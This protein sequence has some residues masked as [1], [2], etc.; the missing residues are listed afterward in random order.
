M[1]PTYKCAEGV[2]SAGTCQVSQSGTDFLVTPCS[3]LTE[4][5]VGFISSTPVTMPANL[6]LTTGKCT[7]QQTATPNQEPIIVYAGDKCDNNTYQCYSSLWCVPN[8]LFC[9]PKPNT[10]GVCTDDR[11]CDKGQYCNTGKCVSVI[12][13]AN[14][15]PC[16]PNPGPFSNDCGFGMMCVDFA[17][18]P[19]C[20]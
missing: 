3:N 12:G 15:S 1:C 17:N 14:A 5:C 20:Q 4:A 7:T 9:E 11:D 16:N 8:E 2:Q 13:P 10:N 19:R 6:E 18:E